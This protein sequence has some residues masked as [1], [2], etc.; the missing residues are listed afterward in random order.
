MGFLAYAKYSQRP[1][2]GTRDARIQVLHI[3]TPFNTLSVRAVLGAM[4][5]VSLAV[6]RLDKPYLDDLDTKKAGP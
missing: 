6:Q 3:Q 1:S 4:P 5:R 2:R